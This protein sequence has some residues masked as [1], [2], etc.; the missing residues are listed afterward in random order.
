MHAAHS[1]NIRE[2]LR[3]AIAQSLSHMSTTTTFNCTSNLTI[4]WQALSSALLIAS[5]STLGNMERGHQDR[6]VENATDI[7][8]LIHD[9][10]AAHDAHLRNPTSRTLHERFSSMRATV[11]RKLRWMKKNCRARKA[12]HAIIN[13]AKN[14]YDALR[15]VYRPTRFSLH[16]VRS[17]DGVLI[18]NKE[19]L[20]ERWAEYLQNLLNKVHTTDPGFLDDL[21]TLPIIPKLDDPPSNDE[22]EK[23]ILSLKDNKTGG[24]DNIP[25]EVIKYGGC[26][27]HGRQHDFILDCWSA[28]CLPQK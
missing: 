8:S 28:K 23:A 19:L 3:N 13:D 14:F 21:P 1:Q 26:A 5:Q 6:F 16:P 7:R 24:P 11:Q 25:D 20:L 4:E 15:G 12:A 2:E 17:T 18:K 22:V 27:L 10:N 9:K